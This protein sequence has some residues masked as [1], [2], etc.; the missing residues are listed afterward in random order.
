MSRARILIVEDDPQVEFTLKKMLRDMGHAVVAAASTAE[1]AV[2]LARSKHPDV[3]CMD[4]HLEGERDGIEAAGEIVAE[5][6]IPI[7]YISAYS[8]AATLERA[9]KTAPFAYL[10]KPFRRE[11]L[12]VTIEVTLYK[13]E[14]DS[15]LRAQERWMST[16]LRSIG[17]AIISVD[18]KNCVTLLN[19]RAEALC[20]Y[21]AKRAHGRPLADVLCLLSLATEEPVDLLAQSPAP[22]AGPQS[23]MSCVVIDTKTGNRTP[24]DVNVAPIQEDRGAA[25]GSVIVLKDITDRLT[26]E[27]G[28]KDSLANLK[29]VLWE[30]VNAIGATIDKRDPYTAQHQLRVAKLATAMALG[31]NLPE[32]TV[33]S[34][35]MAALLHDIGKIYV[36]AEILSKPTSLDDVEMSLIRCHPR[37]GFDILQAIPFGGPIAEIVHQHHERL[38]GSGYPKGLRNGRILSEASLLAVADV[39]EAMASH[40]PYRPAL[41]IEPALEEIEK[42]AGTLYAVKDVDCCLDLFRNQGFTLDS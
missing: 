5:M 34:I 22:M 32:A 1:K 30:T 27:Q 17:E 12:R 29:R 33:E 15:K 11:E 24:V 13:H 9:K 4:I 21:S 26:Y 23:L 19:A 10:T 28:M 16:T 38:D 7:I 40:R 41:G 20:G 35:R 37:V 8:D 2:A 42:N 3:I 18:D 6:D 36:P 25:S 14:L 39:V 31:Q